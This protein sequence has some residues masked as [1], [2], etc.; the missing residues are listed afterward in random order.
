[1]KIRTRLLL[2]LLPTLVSSIA[3]VSALLAVN[4]HKEIVE[5]FRTRLKSAVVSTA[6]MHPN[7]EQLEKIREQLQV[8]RL[9]LVPI[10]SPDLEMIPKKLHITPIY[11]G[12]EGTKVITGYAPMF[13]S[14]GYIMGL[15]AADI[16][17]SLIDKK[18]HESLFLIIFCAGF[19]ILVVIL[20]LFLIANKIS[21]PVQKL[22]NSALAIAAGH[23]GESVQVS[24]PK[25]I[26]E[27]ANTLNTMS[28]CLHENIN[29]LRENSL[30]RE[31][32]YGEYECAML[33]QHMM[34]QKN[35]DECRSDAMAVKSITFF[36]ES[37]RGLL[38]DFPKLENPDLFQIHLAEAEEEGFEGMY[39]LLTQYKLSKGSFGE[40]HTSLLFDRTLSNIQ[41][42]GPHPPL[43]WSLDDKKFLELSQG[44]LKVDSGDYL[45]FFNQGL[46]R[47]FK[48]QNGIAELLA[49]VLKIF[50]SDGLETTV[51]MLQKEIAFATKRIH[52]KEDIHLLCFQI[53]NP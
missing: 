50:A 11:I 20:T 7:E 19:T 42:K 25:E 35:I 21:N 23:Y 4:W 36:S 41:V 14:N 3:L 40:A 33:L 2:F 15:M 44:A 49:K 6:A 53:L 8:T 16:H 27:L 13:D 26:A 29:R 48:G 18:F 5:G 34:L 24:G 37:P 43:F 47:F 1:M 31:R 17:V 51:S 39:Q 45:F 22:N 28:E 30:V 9:Y 52:L 46:T 38:L 12:K 32:M 10:H